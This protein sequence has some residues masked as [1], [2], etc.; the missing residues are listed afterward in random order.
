MA[1]H[2]GML[3]ILL[4]IRSPTQILSSGQK[5]LTSMLENTWHQRPII[6]CIILDTL[7]TMGWEHGF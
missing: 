5:I 3:D 7:E 4:S 1:L 2:F 6:Q